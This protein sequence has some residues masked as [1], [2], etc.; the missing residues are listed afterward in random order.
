MHK[1]ITAAL[2]LLTTT[3]CAPGFSGGAGDKP[4][5]T[6]LVRGRL[7]IPDEDLLGRQVTGLQVAALHLDADGGIAAFP[8][9]VFDPS[10]QRDQAS[11][12]ATVGAG[13]DTVLVLQVPSATQRSAGSFLALYTFDGDSLVPRGEDDLELGTLSVT[14][15]ARVPADTTITG[16]ASATPAAQ[17]DTDGDGLSNDV[18]DDD[19]DDGTPDAS[20]DDV[21][22]DG[23]PDA[24][25]RL[26]ALPDADGDGVADALR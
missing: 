2:L 14:R 3:A 10:A 5:G 19:D 1:T 17:T 21:A 4:A 18:D 7:Q 16:G 9:A 13:V 22:G 20:D 8:S 23:V 6:R 15:G 11:F 25:Q 26:S 12:V 24:L